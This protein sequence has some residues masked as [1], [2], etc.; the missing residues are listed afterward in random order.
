MAAN[1]IN[2]ATDQRNW[3]AER[4]SDVTKAKGRP[5]DLS[6]KRGAYDKKD[7]SAAQ[8]CVIFQGFGP[9]IDAAARESERHFTYKAV[10]F[11]KPFDGMAGDLESFALLC[12]GEIEEAALKDHQLGGKVNFI[13]LEQVNQLPTVND[14][15][16][17]LDMR[18]VIQNTYQGVKQNTAPDPEP[19]P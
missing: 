12:A 5:V 4:L 16:Y 9:N 19:A 14:E 18:F 15:L 3:L 11:A 10:L 13:D 17:V 7:T 2:L 6:V 1:W 8:V